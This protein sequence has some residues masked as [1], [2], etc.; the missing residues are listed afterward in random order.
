M[1]ESAITTVQKPSKVFAEQGKKQVGALTSAI[2][3]SVVIC[4]S[5]SGHYV[6]PGIIFPRKKLNPMLYDKHH[7]A[8]YVLQWKW[9]HDIRALR[10]VD[11]TFK[12]T[13]DKVLLI[14]DGHSSHKSIQAVELV[15]KSGVMM[16]YLSPHCTHRLQPL[17]LNLG[18]LTR[19]TIKK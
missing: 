11:A 13:T 16:F 14:L 10:K 18:H 12:P 17:D 19:I 8:L 6:P 5:P 1:D 15:K 2:H 4:V 7:Q 3:V 9:V